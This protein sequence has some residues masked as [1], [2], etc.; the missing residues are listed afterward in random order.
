[1]I[2]L[3]HESISGNSKIINFM[4]IDIDILWNSGM[5]AIHQYTVE[6]PDKDL[7]YSHVGLLNIN[8]FFGCFE[9]LA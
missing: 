7:S 8:N 3:M 5:F 1:M 6:T 9:S 2:V 4:T